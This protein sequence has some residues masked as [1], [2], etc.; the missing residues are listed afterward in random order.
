MGWYRVIK[1]I[2][3]NRYAYDQR[4]YRQGGKVRSENRYVGPVG[5][6]GN[7]TSQGQ[8]KRTGARD[9]RPP[10]VSVTTTAIPITPVTTTRR[11]ASL[12]EKM[13]YLGRWYRLKNAAGGW[14]AARRVLRHYRKFTKEDHAYLLEKWNGH[15]TKCEQKIK[16]GKSKRQTAY[17]TKEQKLSKRQWSMLVEAIF[18]IRE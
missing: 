13:E 9:A 7:G 17:W 6:G 2:K 10:D 15:L 3:G 5:G 14:L 1:T 12:R 16:S 8:A 18:L 11:R 4:T